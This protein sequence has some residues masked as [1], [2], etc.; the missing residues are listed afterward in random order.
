MATHTDADSM[1]RYYHLPCFL[2][3]GPMRFSINE[4]HRACFGAAVD[5]VELA[6]KYPDENA[7]QQCIFV[8]AQVQGRL[9]G[10]M[11]VRIQHI[12]TAANMDTAV[13]FDSPAYIEC[14]AVNIECTAANIECVAC[15]P[16]HGVQEQTIFKGLL[17]YL[18]EEFQHVHLTVIDLNRNMFWYDR[19]KQ[20]LLSENFIACVKH[21]KH[22]NQTQWWRMQLHAQ[23]SHNGACPCE[24][25]GL[26]TAEEAA[27]AEDTAAQKAA[28]PFTVLP[29]RM[30]VHRRA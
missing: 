29:A 5:W 10:C 22:K 9:C 28:A 20:T 30:G 12:D 1:V 14:T 27:H 13:S 24:R 15:L 23:I 11:Q 16:T 21:D 17:V 19:L 7:A 4:C 25:L 18:R 26:H 6:E 3:C 2:I 8:L